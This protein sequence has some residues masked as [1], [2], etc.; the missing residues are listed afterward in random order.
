MLLK[1]F[2]SIEKEG[3]VLISF[4]DLPQSNAGKQVYGNIDGIKLVLTENY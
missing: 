1:L 3:N 4:Y 2:E